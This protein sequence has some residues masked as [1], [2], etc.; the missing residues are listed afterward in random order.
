M[1]IPDTEYGSFEDPEIET[2]RSIL[3]DIIKHFEPSQQVT[4]DSM[5]TNELMEIIEDHF[6]SVN[7]KTICV[8]MEQGGFR[9]SFSYASSQLVWMMKMKEA[10]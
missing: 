6:G 2:V 10:E 7:K 8:C 3:N 9:S 4:E 1:P 5:T